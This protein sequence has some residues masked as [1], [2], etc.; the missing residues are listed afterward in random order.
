MDIESGRP[1]PSVSERLFGEAYRF[2]FFQAVRLLEHVQRERARGDPLVGC[3]P[4]GVDSAP[5]REAVR[6][7]ALP[8]LSFPSGTIA[9]LHDETA[10]EPAVREPPEMRV[11]F[12]GLTGP[13]GVLP[14]NYTD[15][16]IR[17]IR[18]KDYAL[19]DFLDLFN[20][21]SISLFYRAWEKYRLPAAWERARLDPSSAEDLFSNCLRCLVGFGTAH[22]HECLSVRDDVFLYYSGHFAHRPRSAVALE[23]LLS[24]YLQQPVR[25]EQFQGQWLRLDE[26]EQ[27]RLP[28]PVGPSGQYHQLGVNAVVGER[29]WDVRSKFRLRLGPLQYSQFTD[30][31]PG[32]AALLRLCEIARAFVG[33]ELAFDVQPVLEASEVPPCRLATK[34]AYSPRLGWNT[35]LGGAPSGRNAEDALFML[36][37][38]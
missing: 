4:V 12:M 6:F 9:D 19:R 23:A 38:V 36:E 31:M 37:S 16:L 28:G 18:R 2:E 32:G 29:V 26:T 7:K 15:L 10:G 5:H 22:L 35:W 27:T 13:S 30:L 3:F 1:A 8:S 11:A 25:V 14:D 17:R 21:R 33:P 20:H 34:E 24:E